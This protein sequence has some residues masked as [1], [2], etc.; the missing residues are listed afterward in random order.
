MSVKYIF[1]L[2]SPETIKISSDAEIKV[3]NSIEDFKDFFN[4]AFDIYKDNEYWVSPFWS[5][6][7]DFFKKKNSFWSHS[8]SKLFVA[9]K[10]DKPVGRIGA[11][12]DDYYCKEVNKKVGFFGFF[13]CVNDKKIA[14]ELLNVAQDWLKSQKS[15]EMQ[16]PVNGR[17]D[18]G[19]GFVV[20]GFDSIPYLLGHYSH[21]YYNDFVENFNM[22]KSRDLVSYHVD[23]KKP[24]SS[25]LKEKAE[26]CEEKG[27]KIRRLSRFKI[28]KEMDWWLEMFMSI[29]ADH[30]GY[31]SVSSYEIKNR[32]GI[33]ELKWIVDTKLFLVAEVNGKPVGFR[34]TL[35]DYNVLFRDLNGKLGIKGVL[36]VLFSRRKIN[37]GRFIIMGVEKEYRGI[38]IG[39]CLNYYN[40]LEM[41][42]RGYDSAEYGWIDEGNVASRKAGEKL[43]GKLYKIYRVY[44]KKI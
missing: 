32:F 29:F 21:K 23:L 16:G 30:W 44:E 42:K 40:L 36:Y 20:K 39:T 10:K 24:I 5:E 9:Y 11:F 19:S 15:V 26:S 34:W 28:S 41:K 17:V 1:E 2:N 3:V 38:G 43:G 25:K 14:L 12:I 35:P 7:R 31:T 4:A 27:I 8:R 13:E 18:L 6:L 33:K 22:K 37:R